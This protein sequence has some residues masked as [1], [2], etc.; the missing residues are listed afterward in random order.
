MEG[1]CMLRF[2]QSI[3]IHCWTETNARLVKQSFLGHF[4][5]IKLC[6]IPSELVREK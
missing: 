6:F 3:L 5:K 4:Y 2:L 1:T